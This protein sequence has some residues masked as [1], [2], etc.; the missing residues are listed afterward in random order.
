VFLLYACFSSIA[1]IIWLKH[2]GTGPNN[3]LKSHLEELTQDEAAMTIWVA[4]YIFGTGRKIT[5]SPLSRV[6]HSFKLW[7]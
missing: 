5:V 6:S 7:V 1:P 2:E 4:S 3:F